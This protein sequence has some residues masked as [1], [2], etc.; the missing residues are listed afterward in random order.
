IALANRASET[1]FLHQ[2]SHFFMVHL[3]PHAE[4]THADTPITL[5]I[6]TKIISSLYLFKVRSVLLFTAHT[7]VSSVHPP[8][9]SGAGYPRERTHF[10]DR[11][12]RS[13]LFFILNERKDVTC[14]AS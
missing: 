10:L 13:C 3:D 5:C 11:E 7:I 4:Q 1:V 14:R 12:K 2:T 6:S 9:V 8:V